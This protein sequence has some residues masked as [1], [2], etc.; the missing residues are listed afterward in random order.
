MRRRRM[1]WPSATSRDSITLMS[2]LGHWVHFIL[3]PLTIKCAQHLRCYMV[4]VF[5]HIV[6]R[7]S[8]IALAVAFC[9]QFIAVLFSTG[10]PGEILEYSTQNAVTRGFAC[11]L[12][13]PGISA[14][15]RNILR[16]LVS[17]V[18][19]LVGVGG[20]AAMA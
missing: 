5:P 4:L 11:G 19:R 13:A 16:F 7:V 14:L 12:P 20:F 6:L 17:V 15:V 9:K 1:A 8:N 2:S 3:P 18:F 10:C